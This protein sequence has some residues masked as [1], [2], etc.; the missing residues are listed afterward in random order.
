MKKLLLLLSCTFFG[1]IIAQ[2]TVWEQVVPEIQGAPEVSSSEECNQSIPTNG[3]ENGLFFNGTIN[4]FLAIDI[5]VTTG[6]SFT[7]NTIKLNIINDVSTVHSVKFYN[8]DSN[9]MP[10]EIIAEMMNLPI[11]S[12][13]I[14]G[15][16]H[17]A[18]FRTITIDFPNPVVLSGEPKFWMAVDTDALGWELTSNHGNVIENWAAVRNDN[19]GQNW[20]TANYMSDL[21]YE[22]V[23]ECE[24]LSTNESVKKTISIFPN[25]AQDYVK[26]SSDSLIE[27]AF[28]TDMQGRKMHISF[29]GQNI[30]VS[31]LKAGVYILSLNFKNGDIQTVKF[32]KK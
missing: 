28:I 29:Y 25:P 20:Q 12:N 22:L 2:Q 8:E 1:S 14:A 15:T 11:V 3:F 5:P 17:G 9:G 23:G 18:T 31:Q 27:N 6:N 13:V 26:V 30:D 32:I 7:I 24:T 19:T 21:V 16:N 4:Q 10:G